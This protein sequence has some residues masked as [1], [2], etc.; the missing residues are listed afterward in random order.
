[1]ASG[2]SRPAAKMA[3]DPTRT[4]K[5]QLRRR[6]LM[7]A[8]EQRHALLAKSRALEGL[9]MDAS[10]MA[11]AAM[12]TIDMAAIVADEVRRARAGEDASGPQSWD[13][14]DEAR[15]QAQLGRDAYLELMAAA[16]QSLIDELE[17][18]AGGG[19]GEWLMAQEYEAYLAAEEEDLSLA[20]AA[21]AEYSS[22]PEAGDATVLCPLCVRA[23]LT[24]TS[25]G[26]VACSGAADGCTLRLDAR[27]H[28]APLELLRERM[29]SLLSEHG[30]RCGGQP[31]CRLPL[32]PA[33]QALGMLL[34]CCPVCGIAT[35]VV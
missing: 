21:D 24:L 1:M 8:A 7:R 19:S 33:E 23:H 34:F 2:A 5:D 12:D 29:E 22:Q 27:G 3:R 18:G 13:E 9:A 10:D 11:P 31:C 32:N 30:R 20:A 4:I 15:L 17:T 28:P 14:A 26:C 16:E 25:D 35:G 6:C